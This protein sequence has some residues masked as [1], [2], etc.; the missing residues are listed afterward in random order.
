MI[1]ERALG[2]SLAFCLARLMPLLLAAEE[3][4][5]ALTTNQREL[6]SRV[7]FQRGRQAGCARNQTQTSPAAAA[8]HS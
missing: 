2:Q 6:L 7:R 3:A 1:P 5:A 8:R 4:A